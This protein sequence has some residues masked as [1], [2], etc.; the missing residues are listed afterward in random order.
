MSSKVILARFVALAIPLVL[1][2]VAAL[3]S[4][5]STP[6]FATVDGTV[7]NNGVQGAVRL[8]HVPLQPSVGEDGFSSKVAED[9]TFHLV[10]IPPGTYRLL[11]DAENQLHGVYG[12]ADLY[13]S[14]T[15]IQIHPGEHLRGLAIRLLPDP[16]AICGQVLDA[17]GQPT[18]ATVEA[19]GVNADFGSV[20]RL[21]SPTQLTNADGRF[22]FPNL[23]NQG[24]FFLRANG[25]WYPSAVSFSGARLLEPARAATGGH[26]VEIRLQPDRCKGVP[27]A[28]H[29]VDA[30]KFPIFE[31]EIALYE[32]NPSGQLF[33][34]QVVQINQ[35][36]GVHLENVCPDR[37]I[38]SMRDRW[39]KPQLFV[40][41]IFTVQPPGGSVDLHESSQ[42]DLGKIVAAELNQPP[43]ASAELTIT[44]EGLTTKEGCSSGVIQQAS[45]FREGDR[46]AAFATADKDGLFRWKNLLSGNY[47]IEYG[48]W[49]HN[50]VN[51]KTFSVDGKDADPTDFYISPGRAV[52]VHVVLSNLPAK[53]PS[54][55]PLRN[56]SSH[57][58]PAGFHPPASLVG[59]VEGE[60]AMDSAAVL[61]SIR[62]NS[63]RSS[64]Y[65]SPVASDGNFRF[66][67]IDPGLY[68][69]WVESPG[70]PVSVYGAEGVGL[71]G[72]PLVFTAGQQIK[73]LKVNLFPTPGICGRVV[74][75]EGNPRIGVQIGFQ[76][77]LSQSAQNQT[78]RTATTDES[79][80]FDLKSPAV[81]PDL[82]LW[83]QERGTR[84]F[85]PWQ[86]NYRPL[87]ITAKS[88]DDSYNSRCPYTLQMASPAE[89]NGGGITIAGTV[90]GTYSPAKG[91]HLWAILSPVSNRLAPKPVK[92]DIKDMSFAFSAITPGEYILTLIDGL[93]N[94]M[95]SCSAVCYG[96][97]TYIR[98]SQKVTVTASPQSNLTLQLR[99]LPQVIGELTIDGKPPVPGPQTHWKDW[100][101]WLVSSRHGQP[102]DSAKL[103]ERGHFS[104]PALGTESHSFLF[105]Y[106]WPDYAVRK[107]TIDGNEVSPDDIR[108]TYGQVAHMVV[109]VTTVTSQGSVHSSPSN[110][111]VDSFRDL[112][113]NFVGA[114]AYSALLIPDPISSPNP[115]FPIKQGR[116]T[117]T[118][119]TASFHGILPGHYRVLAFENLLFTNEFRRRA[120]QALLENPDLVQALAVFGK[121]VEVV[122]GKPFDF[123]APLITEKLQGLLAQ[124]GIPVPTYSTFLR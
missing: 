28:A 37:Y 90:A 57:D 3:S 105:N 55:L 66:D 27:L 109:D 22:R 89:G 88:G 106:F 53:H 61:H 81:P 80:R 67:R 103:D 108:L 102:P 18:L 112:C 107:I 56:A 14:G 85:Y 110:P 49:A 122:A 15:L 94:A 65:R 26:C 75:L 52:Q 104:L 72:T 43:L 51:L 92:I 117:G 12:A 64:E 39:A 36:D 86:P 87:S 82:E 124:F 34:S 35:A 116:E 30:L 78:E 68:T 42:P 59:K 32:I 11:A 115:Q 23:F 48:F 21:E 33:D 6:A 13:Q 60:H 29:F 118:L 24:H 69:L 19:Y 54:A 96:E 98:D 71:E 45:L 123:E 2:S 121:P 31:Y 101:A 25:T 50:A 100:T 76:G 79:G 120:G 97:T 113:A 20:T 91:E 46:N 41:P 10:D 4:A 9:G 44:L 8:E 93:G 38:A 47:R 111:P 16:P 62:F 119:Y 114:P 83:E 99:P 63:A 77:F 58:L 70:N 74:D 7:T 17:A 95:M 5:Q 73:N 40:S 1:L 84:T